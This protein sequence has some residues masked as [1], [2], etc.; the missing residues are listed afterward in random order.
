MG[1]AA[2]Q[3][4]VRLRYLA[5]GDS[6][7]AGTGTVGPE[8]AF[9]AR[10]AR[11]AGEQLGVEI[12]VTNPAVDGFA[13]ADVIRQELPLLQAVR[14][15]LVSIL[16]GANDLAR[17]WSREVYAQGLQTIYEAIARAVRDPGCVLAVTVPDWSP[18]PAA[19]A[20]GSPDHLRREIDWRNEHA[21]SEA[22]RRGFRV[23][24]VAPISRRLGPAGLGP[25]GLHP[26]QQQYDLWAD[27]MWEALGRDWVRVGASR[28]VAFGELGHHLD[29]GSYLRLPELLDLQS[30]R[31]QHH[32]EVFFIVIHQAYELWFKL[33]LRELEAAR[34]AL[35][36]GDAAGA[37]WYLRRVGAVG[38][39]LVQQIGLLDT[40]APQDFLLFRSELS[41]ASGFQSV[42]FREI[43]FLGGLPD[44]SYLERLDL[45]AGDRARLE[46]RLSEPTVRD[47]WKSLVGSAGNPPLTEIYGDR[48]RHQELFLT[49]EAL[50]DVDQQLVLW[51]SRH[52]TMVERQIG[53]K[54]GT[55][56]SAGAA[57]LRTT[58]ERRLFPELW[59][60]RSQ[61]TQ[62]QV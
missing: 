20:F 29:Y 62:A 15:H 37:R 54:A 25:D 36:A 40:M 43:E 9:P 1:E 58:L 10:L 16:V 50:L 19:A 60:A 38:A 4:S 6:Y 52:L 14:P 17:G 34:D 3:S 27:E 55:G 31:T 45:R 59:A 41:P 47:G 11:L 13:T 44:P 51:R 53:T 56:G 7:T 35:L 26:T 48:R 21:I 46:R 12:D 8:H 22:R 32:D 30:P 49:A 18:A 5:L 61:L 33:Q 2:P 57:Y 24:D 23:F 28:S 42:Q 39:L